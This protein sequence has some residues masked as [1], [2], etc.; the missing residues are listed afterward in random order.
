MPRRN[1][2]QQHQRDLDFEIHE[3]SPAANE[4][5]EQTEAR[6]F[7]SALHARRFSNDGYDYHTPRSFNGMTDSNLTK[8][9][10]L[11]NETGDEDEAGHT[12]SSMMDDIQAE[13]EKLASA[14]APDGNDRI[15]EDETFGGEMEPDEK[16]ALM[17]SDLEH[18]PSR[19]ESSNTHSSEEEDAAASRR[20]S[21]VSAFSSHKSGTAA[22]ESRRESIL[23]T[24]SHLSGH[25]TSESRR[26]SGISS[27]SHRTSTD[28]SESRRVSESAISLTSEHSSDYSGHYTEHAEEG[29]ASMAET[30][31]HEDSATED[32]ASRRESTVSAASHSTHDRRT[33]VSDSRRESIM[34]GITHDQ[35]TEGS[36]SRRE[37]TMSGGTHNQYTEA[38]ASRRESAYSAVS[39]DHGSDAFAS[40][41]ESVVSGVSYSTDRRSSGRTEALIQKAARDIITEIEKQK[42]RV[43]PKPESV[44]GRQSTRSESRASSNRQSDTHASIKDNQS[45]RSDS[46]M[47]NTRSSDVHSVKDNHST[48]SNSRMSN[49]RASE[50]HESIKD[51]RSNI[52][53]SRP[54]SA[55]PSDMHTPVPD[56][57]QATVEDEEEEDLRHNVAAD[58]AEDNSSSHNEHEDDVFSDHSPRSSVGSMS[59]AEHRKLEDT[60]THRHR[61]TRSS[62]ISDFS[63]LEED[64]DDEEDFIP[65]VRGTPRPPF[66]SP[67][68][69]RALQM[70][71]PPP[72][73][74][75]SP[76]SS[77]RTPLPTVSRL[78]SPMSGMQ[79]SPKKTPPRFKRNTPPLVLLHVTLLP[80]Q[81]P[82]GHVLENAHPD[83]LSQGAKNVRDTWRQ[84][85]DRMGDTTCERGILLPHPQE[86]FE[87]LEERLLEALELPLRRRARILE[88]GHYLGPS[89]EMTLDEESDTEDEYSEN[90]RHSRSSALDRQTHWCGTCQ[91]EIRYDALG[92]GKVFRIKIY[93]SNGLMK[94]GA[95]EACWK[96]MER[97]DVE[98]E[99]IV[100]PAVQDEISR[101]VLEQEK[102]MELHHA[103]EEEL[104]EEA[105]ASFLE[106]ESSV[107]YNAPS[108]PPPPEA[109]GMMP[110][111]SATPSAPPPGM[112]EDERRWREEQRMREIYGHTPAGHAEHGGAA[113]DA[114]PSSEYT[115][116][117]TPASPSAEAYARQEE[118]RQAPKADSL[119]ELLLEA[120]KVMMQDKKNVMIAIMGVLVLVL[121][122][123]VGAARDAHRDAMM[124]Q[125]IMEAPEAPT[126]TVT[127]RAAEQQTTS[128]VPSVESVSSASVATPSVADVVSET[129]VS[130]AGEVRDADADG[131]EERESAIAEKI[132]RVVETVTEVSV[133]VETATVTAAEAAAETFAPIEQ[134]T[135]TQ[136]E[137]VGEKDVEEVTLGEVTVEDGVLE[138]AEETPGATEEVTLED[139]VLEKAVEDDDTLEDG[140]R[141]MTVEEEIVLED[142]VL[143][144]AEEIPETTEKEVTLED[145]ETLGATGEKLEEVLEEVLE[146]AQEAEETVKEVEREL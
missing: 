39:Q 50:D 51:Y 132:I 74:I 116:R 93:A 25:E 86:D 55:R 114:M 107:I 26:E 8:S 73:V 44:D 141:E 4:L 117:E 119:P 128:V 57:F 23:S 59:E 80:L 11:V 9:S 126:V 77:K 34:S 89:N 72:S 144:K 21:G 56:H 68:S 109:R 63:R 118:R 38:S 90:F 18:S 134:D 98:L 133:M 5:D 94:A 82:W 102:A 100:E 17:D 99:P 112:H 58:E 60:V 122:L 111:T 135:Q 53:G 137:T 46:R 40:R 49:A 127:E 103:D 76:R 1:R 130:E 140:A 115:H 136:E 61:S 129:T 64:Q 143:E 16:A 71:S 28:A 108:S 146:V 139:G 65:T 27:T 101:H 22:S 29:E 20:E 2:R 7:A 66:R 84:L 110:S 120:F 88:C 31:L 113:E 48:R 41:R 54:P 87:I 70:S 83:D 42:G 43:S 15:E 19:R 131:E 36:E 95:W 92:P 13:K 30:S 142:A 121:A 3:D 79:Y 52:S 123:R 106:Q 47:S 85:Q 24:S 96:E 138:R 62:R 37:S 145:G 14:A 33:D 12:I 78:G 97:V 10:T 75:G 81:W 91:T 67:S 6:D 125:P 104:P 69:V 105:N 45:V 35:Y 32:T 124:F